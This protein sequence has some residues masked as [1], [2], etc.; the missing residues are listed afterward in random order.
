MNS[1]I[2]LVLI[3]V[4]VIS[5]LIGSINF[6]ILISK[7]ISGKDI[8]E[9]GSGNAGATNMLRTY[10]K[11][12]GILTLVL[13]VLKG[14]IVILLTIAA[15]KWVQSYLVES[16]PTSL[17][18]TRPIPT[19]KPETL[20]YIAGV[21]VILGH[22]FPLYFGFKGGK[23]VATSLGVVLMLDWKVGL[24]IAVFAIAIMAITRYVSLGSVLGGAAYILIEGTKIL[25]TDPVNKVCFVCVVI[26]GGLLI[27]RHHANIK[28]L[29]C[30]NENKLSF[31]KK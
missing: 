28:R 4:A 26:L 11:K 2:V 6:S 19:I 12:M 29:M 22:N 21:C 30:G 3:A 18:Q 17:A 13:D 24:I 8:R 16:F 25:V 10:G 7:A 31:K 1:Q 20:K 9:S 23:G 27:V 14:I 15:S 5:Y